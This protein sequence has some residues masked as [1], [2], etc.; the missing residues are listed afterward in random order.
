[1]AGSVK[2]T[3]ATKTTYL[4]LFHSGTLCY[5]ALWLYE[6]PFPYKI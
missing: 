1:M 2:D 4:L 5:M 6:V 3:I